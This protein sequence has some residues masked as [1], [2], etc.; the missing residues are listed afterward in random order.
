MTIGSGRLNDETFEKYYMQNLPPPQFPP[1]RFLAYASV[2][3][4]WALNTIWPNLCLKST[5]DMQLLLGFGPKRR[6]LKIPHAK[7]NFLSRICQILLSIIEIKLYKKFGK[8][9]DTSIFS[10]PF[11]LKGYCNPKGLA[12]WLDS[13]GL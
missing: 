6:T 10:L 12:Q 2:S 8:N 11:C 9:T 13:L 5:L 3:C 4:P 7:V 1:C